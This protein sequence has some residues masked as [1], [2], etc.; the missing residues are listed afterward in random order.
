MME[1]LLAAGVFQAL[2]VV[3]PLV[4]QVVIDKVI[5][6]HGVVTLNVLC[7]GL[8]IVLLFQLLMD[9]SRR[10]LFAHTSW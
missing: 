9:C 6:N 1:I 10:I 8:L 3:L 5:V 2:G 4:T 7:G